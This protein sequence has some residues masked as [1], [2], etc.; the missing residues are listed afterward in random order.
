MALN[1]FIS[2]STYD[3]QNAKNLAGWVSQA[4]A[5]P[6]ISQYSLMPGTPLSPTII[7]KIKNCDIFLLL[8]SENAKNSEWVS[9]EIG[10]AV[11]NNK[12]II[13]LVLHQGIYLPGFIKD[14]KYIDVYKDPVAATNE[15]YSTIAIYVKQKEQQEENIKI[16]FGVAGAIL[17][18]VAIAG[19]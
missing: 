9:Q 19:K 14:L 11:G 6:F 8:W 3:I 2:Y 4:G 1:V 5:Q 18:F 15:I 17:L 10:I 13:P 12:T 16:I 7:N